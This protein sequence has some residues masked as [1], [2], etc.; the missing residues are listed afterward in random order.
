MTMEMVESVPPYLELSTL[1]AL[2]EIS[3]HGAPALKHP[4]T[5]SPE[6]ADFIGGC[7]VF[8]VAKRADSF[9]LMEHP[10]LRRACT[11]AELAGL[12]V[13]QTAS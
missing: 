12:L 13:Y 5:V 8:D 11:P 1:K 10:F 9:T 4:E 2:I 3:T 6:L 7:L